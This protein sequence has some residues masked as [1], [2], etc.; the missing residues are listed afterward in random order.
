MAQIDRSL[1]DFILLTRFD[2]CYE[3][4]NKLFENNMLYQQVDAGLPDKVGEDKGERREE[5]P[6]PK[7]PNLLPAAGPNGF[8]NF[9]RPWPRPRRTS[10]TGGARLPLPRSR[11]R[12]R[13]AGDAPEREVKGRPR[14]SAPLRPPSPRWGAL[15]LLLI[16][17]P[18]ATR[19]RTLPPGPAHRR[20]GTPTSSQSPLACFL[21]PFVTGS[22]Q[23]SRLRE[24]DWAVAAA[25]GGGGRL[26]RPANVE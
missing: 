22:R 5:R 19:A 21:R 2:L 8:N 20:P 17:P 9:R 10:H 13:R 16:C 18:P 7:T 26:W 1:P 3:R 6:T 15:L 14:P 11:P 24:L 4:P 23:S 12:W 25:G